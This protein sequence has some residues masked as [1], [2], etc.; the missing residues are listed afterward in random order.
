[1]TSRRIN[2][3]YAIQGSHV[4]M[5]DYAHS[6]SSVIPKLPVNT[7][8]IPILSNLVGNPIAF[9][10]TVSFIPMIPSLAVFV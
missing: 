1:M 10:V 8:N 9:A 7:A 6:V 5:K 2:V 3:L 4:F